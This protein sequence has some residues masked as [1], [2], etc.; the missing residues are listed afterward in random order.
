MVAVGG[1]LLDP[2]VALSS[3][4]RLTEE[5]AKAID[6]LSDISHADVDSIRGSS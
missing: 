5:L 3:M 6:K 2:E 4:L 1:V